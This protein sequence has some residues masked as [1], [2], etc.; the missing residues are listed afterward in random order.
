MVKLLNIIFIFLFIRFIWVYW[1]RP[2]FVDEAEEQRQRQFRQAQQVRAARQRYVSIL[3]PLVARIA[4]AD[5]VISVAEIDFI[6]GIFK[7]MGLDEEERATA[8]AIFKRAKDDP[9]IFEDALAHFNL[10]HYSFEAR[11]ATFHTLVNIARIDGGKITPAK[12]ELLFRVAAVFGLPR[13]LVNMLMGQ[14]SGAQYDG[15][16]YRYSQPRQAPV[17]SR[18]EDLALLGLTS[19]ATAAE[20][21]RAYRQKVKELHPDRLQAQGL[22]EPMIKEATQRISEINAAYDRLTRE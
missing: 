1:I 22:P 6:E 15:Y 14:M 2:L 3:M 12:S 9:S 13:P 8:I 4:K 21:K 7:N 17:H 5:G 19:N 18:E 16:Q 11:Y 10:W 20:I